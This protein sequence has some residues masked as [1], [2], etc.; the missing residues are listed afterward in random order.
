[1]LA[2]TDQEVHLSDTHLDVLIREFM[3]HLELVTS[4][5]PQ[6]VFQKFTTEVWLLSYRG[7]PTTVE[8]LVQDVIPNIFQQVWYVCHEPD[9]A[10]KAAC[11]N[12]FFTSLRSLV[13]SHVKISNE[14]DI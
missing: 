5:R 7:P 12:L 9:P 6:Q 3:T 10:G 11:S 8:A 2:A 13:I 4:G 14:V 1:M